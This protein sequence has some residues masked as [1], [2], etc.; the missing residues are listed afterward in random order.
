MT[1]PL[2]SR[3]IPRRVLFGNPE[4]TN[5]RISPD[6]AMLAYL[7][8]F[9]GVLNVWVRKVLGGEAQ[10]VTN[11][12]ERPIH[13]FEWHPGGGGIIHLQDC[14][15]DENFHVYLTD[16]ESGVARD[17][18]PFEGARA[19]ILDLDR[20]F[21]NEMLV[22]VNARDPQCF[23][24][25]RIDLR[26]GEITLEITNPG[27]VAGWCTDNEMRVRVAAVVRPDG[28][29]T[30]RLRD[31]AE[32]WATFLEAGAEEVLDAYGF[33]E[34]GRLLIASSV[35][36]N[37]ARLLA[38]SIE[39][40]SFEVLAEDPE[41][42][43]SGAIVNPATHAIEAIAFERERVQWTHISPEIA[44]DV[45][46]LETVSRGDWRLVSR[47]LADE[48]WTV[49]F[50]VDDGP[51]KYYLYDRNQRAASFLFTT[52]PELA[53]HTLARMEP[54]S[55]VARDGL[56]IHGYLSSPPG[57]T[58]PMPM[59]L[60]VHGGPWVRDSW[61]YRADAQWLANRG[62]GVLQI[63]Y[64][65][66]SG[67]GKAHL[68]A[69]DREWAGKMH[70]DLLD[71]KAWAIREGHADAERFAIYGGSYGGYAVLVAAAFTPGAFRCGIDIVGPSSLLTLLHSIPPYWAPVLAQF[72]RRLGDP[73][74]DEQF[75]RDRSPLYRAEAIVDPLLI[76][77]GANDPR[78]KIAESDQIVRAMRARGKTVEYLV[79]DDEGHGFIRPE[80]RMRFYAA[81]EAFLAAHLGGRAEPPTP[82]E[83]S[84][85]MRR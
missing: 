18:T 58:G 63:N 1:G 75:L 61:G 2:E 5:A 48:R 65:G 57:Q 72:K 13:A 47:D 59:V 10:V 14:A 83:S 4:Q 31:E 49:Q 37:A 70:D 45:A 43:I 34:R 68:N 69:G 44:D 23:D 82:E 20:N 30:L 7:A 60:L 6:G 81:A 21:P 71:A 36:A 27:D 66:S 67:Y 85:A 9:N 15:G 55:F 16:I 28:G 24:V 11:D 50:V 84:E 8:P 32:G 38:Y 3:L 12:T 53:T 54:I 74:R 33:D 22:K 19:D 51:S 62:Y 42:D 25:H 77:Q 39:A 40:K 56:T 52:Q 79:F 64:R 78:V 29:T 46:Y 80:N 76:A 26:S 41:Y 17:L 35:D 73:E